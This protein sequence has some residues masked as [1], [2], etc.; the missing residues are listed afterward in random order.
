[1]ISKD[2]KKQMKQSKLCQTLPFI[3]RE[4]E[5]I[6][7]TNFLAFDEDEET[8][9]VKITFHNKQPIH[10]KIGD[11][12]PSTRYL[13]TKYTRGNILSDEYF[14]HWVNKRPPLYVMLPGYICFC[15]DS[16]AA[17]DNKG[18]KITGWPPDITVSPS[19]N[20]IGIYHGF[21]RN[22]LIS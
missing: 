14:K 2:T 4:Q 15:V 10:P 3:P 11:M 7:S 22:G 18:W 5:L 16:R 12:W 19:I 17:C 13:Q 9:P 20:I 8:L 1:M 6:T 21:I